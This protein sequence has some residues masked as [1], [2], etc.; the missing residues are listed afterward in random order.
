MKKQILISFGLLILLPSIA[1]ASFDAD[2]HYGSTGS[3]VTAL[4]EFLIDQGVLKGQATGNFYSLTL[5]AVKEF[6]KAEG[7]NPTSG[8]FGPTTRTVA[9]QILLAQ[10]PNSEGNATVTKSGVDLSQQQN[11][12]TVT[13]L[14]NQ[15]NA[16]LAQ[17]QILNDQAKDRTVVQQQTPQIINQQ[18]ASTNQ[19]VTKYPSSEN[20]ANPINPATGKPCLDS[21]CSLDLQLELLKSQISRNANKS[22]PPPAFN[23]SSPSFVIPR[24]SV[25]VEKYWEE[26]KRNDLD[27]S[28]C[29]RTGGSLIGGTCF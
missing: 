1:F 29:E 16:L 7:I 12:T 6:Q 9:N 27:R 20:R 13:G 15:L 2:L 5:K 19:Q 28:L 23:Y 26:K 4:Q 17:L 21:T 25:A 18:Q 10:V 3:A 11:Q 8:Y 22:N 24:E 14:Q